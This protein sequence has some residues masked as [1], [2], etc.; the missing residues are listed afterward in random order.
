MVKVSLNLPWVE[1]QPYTGATRFLRA[2]GERPPSHMLAERKREV[3]RGPIVSVNVFIL[4][5]RAYLLAH[6][7]LSHLLPG[8]RRACLIVV[9]SLLGPLRS[10]L[11]LDDLAKARFYTT[12]T[13]SGAKI[14]A[15]PRMFGGASGALDWPFGWAGWWPAHSHPADARSSTLQF[16]RLL[17]TLSLPDRSKPLSTHLSGAHSPRNTNGSPAVPCLP[18]RVIASST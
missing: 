4:P 3:K 6:K 5:P 15:R 13:R 14:K 2:T 12:R 1:F 7:H 17:N 10:H 16:Q 8:G 18:P 9:G 11:S